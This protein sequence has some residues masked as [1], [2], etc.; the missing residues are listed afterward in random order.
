LRN[1]IDD[2]LAKEQAED[3]YIKTL[4]PM[5]CHIAFNSTARDGSKFD[6]NKLLKSYD[7]HA[8]VQYIDGAILADLLE[9][10]SLYAHFE[11]P[12][13]EHGTGQYW[14]TDGAWEAWLDRWGMHD[15]APPLFQHMLILSRPDGDKRVLEVGESLGDFGAANKTMIYLTFGK[16]L[17]SVAQML[18][19]EWK[20][21]PRL[22]KGD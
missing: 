11:Y 19:E 8:A 10:R 2:A 1:A 13:R 6:P 14:C 21:N 16:K 4:L 15:D 12:T 3:S 18:E 7:V 20:L 5:I 17:G 22:Q 9:G